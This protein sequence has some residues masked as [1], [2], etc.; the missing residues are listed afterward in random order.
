MRRRSASLKNGLYIQFQ[1][2]QELLDSDVLKARLFDQDL[3][4]LFE[5]R[6]NQLD[7]KDF[8]SKNSFQTTEE[9]VLY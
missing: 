3:M 1:L 6:V 5:N 7:A 8:L 4:N 9:K 2:S